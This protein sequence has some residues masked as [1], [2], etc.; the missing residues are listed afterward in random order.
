VALQK[1]FDGLE[2]LPFDFLGLPGGVHDLDPGGVRPR[3]FQ[4]PATDALEES[5][6]VSLKPV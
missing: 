5:Q 6:T 1:I 2:Y 3:Q 4:V